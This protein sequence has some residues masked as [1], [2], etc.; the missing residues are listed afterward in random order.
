MSVEC[1][2]A[3]DT[4]SDWSC[5]VTCDDVTVCCGICDEVTACFE[6]CDDVREPL[7]PR[8]CFSTIEPF[9]VF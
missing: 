9:P 7:E 8:A 5:E 2:C 6:I 3:E 1:A 4:L